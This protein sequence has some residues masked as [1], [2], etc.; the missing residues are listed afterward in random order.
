[1]TFKGRDESSKDMVSMIGINLNACLIEIYSILY[2]MIDIVEYQNFFSN[3][4][5]KLNSYQIDAFR[6]IEKINS[7]FENDIM[8]MQSWIRISGILQKERN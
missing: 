3:Y 1:M 6:T 7:Q 2:S 8:S 5:E 4:I